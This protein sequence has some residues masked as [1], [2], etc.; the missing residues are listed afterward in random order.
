MP[1]RQNF[2]ARATLGYLAGIVAAGVC[3]VTTPMPAAPF[4]WMGAFCAAS[5]AWCAVGAYRVWRRVK[6][7]KGYPF[8]FATVEDMKE[9]AHD[10]RHQDEQ[11][12]GRGFIWENRHAQAAFEITKSDYYTTFISDGGCAHNFGMGW[13]HG[14][15]PKETDL[16]QLLAHTNGHTLITGVPGSGKIS[17][18]RLIVKFVLANPLTAFTSGYLNKLYCTS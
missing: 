4:L 6:L 7:L 10:S 13:L 14:M 1:W 8:S 15:E 2:E 5:G 3:S 16:W 18:T 12:I 17:G 11:Y 9:K